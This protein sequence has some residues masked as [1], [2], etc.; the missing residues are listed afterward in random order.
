[1]SAEKKP[2]LRKFY[3][4]ANVEEDFKMQQYIYALLLGVKY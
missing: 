3:C 2:K 4:T 1:M